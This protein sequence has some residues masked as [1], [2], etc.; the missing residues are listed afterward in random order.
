MKSVKSVLGCLLAATGFAVVLQATLITT[1]TDVPLD[2]EYPVD[3]PADTTNVWTG[4]FSG[5]GSLRKTGLGLLVLANP[6]NVFT[7]GIAID[8]GPLRADAEGALGTEKIT[9]TQGA[10][11]RGCL[12]FNAQDAV[13]PNDIDVI[14]TY[15]KDYRAC[16]TFKNVTLTGNVTSTGGL[17]VE[18]YPVNGTGG[19]SREVNFQSTTWNGTITAKG[20]LIIRTYGTNVFNAAVSATGAV[21]F[22]TV[23]SMMGH[24]FLNS[25]DNSF[26]SFSTYQPKIYCGAANVLSGAYWSISAKSSRQKGWHSLHMNGYDQTLNYLKN[27]ATAGISESCQIRSDK[28][29]VL[30]LTGGSSSTQT[31]GHI[32]CG[33]VSLVVDAT[34]STFVQCF[35]ELNGTV[36]TH[37]TDGT[38]TVKKGGVQITGLKTT[39]ENMPQIDVEASGSLAIDTEGQVTF[40][41]VTTL[42]V[43]GKLEFGASAG[44]PFTDQLASLALDDGAELTVNTE[45][46]VIFG[47]VT[48]AGKPLANDDYTYPDDRVPQLKAGGFTVMGGAVVEESSWTGAG[49]Q[50]A[51]ITDEANW[52]ET[53]LDFTHGV[54]SP[55]FASGGSSATVSS[56][57][58]FKNIALSAAT[59][60]DGF[61]FA[62]GGDAGLIALA[63]TELTLAIA[64]D[65]K[66]YDFEVPVEGRGVT[67]D[68]K[69]KLTITVPTN[70]LLRLNGGVSYP[71]GSVEFVGN[72]GLGSVELR[73]E[74]TIGGA[75]T[76]PDGLNPLIAGRISTPGHVDQGAASKGGAYTLTSSDSGS[77]SKD[78]DGLLLDNALIEKPVYIP[79]GSSTVSRYAL[80]GMANSTNEIVGNLM[81]GK[82]AG[83]TGIDLHKNSE[84]TLCG[85]L[86]IQQ[87]FHFFGETG[88]RLLINEKPVSCNVAYKYQTTKLWLGLTVVGGEVVFG[89]AGNEINY[90]NVGNASKYASKVTFMQDDLFAAT[91]TTLTAG[92]AISGQKFVVA[93]DSKVAPI[94]EFNGTKQRFGR[95]AAGFRATFHGTEGSLL[96]VNGEQVADDYVGE[97]VLMI[98]APF[99]GA[100]GLKMNGTGTLVLSNGV[101]TSVGGVEVASG[102]LRFAPGTKW[103]GASLALSGDGVLSIPSGTRLKF[104]SLAVDGE[105]APGGLYTYA[106]APEAIR[107]HLAATSGAIQIGKPG[108]VLLLR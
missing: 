36:T 108:L 26:S 87:P 27:D 81:F 71:D 23:A 100:L 21:S 78:D 25:A 19:G 9:I 75:L 35:G 49:T 33:K 3:V 82:Q 53:G 22:G 62:K 96:E 63:G 40:P 56:E 105:P 80:W 93:T 39:F 101:N 69:K 92:L 98:A 43:A 4:C 95:V 18:N 59:G 102:E 94:V 13:F 84:L 46:K 12:Q 8:A 31:T 11:P 79:A 15:N 64:E 58:V 60:E 74:S 6:N 99:T 86:N 51:E 28:P 2:G 90:L 97:D 7:G 37:T 17:A 107:K 106:T 54:L 104:K 88:A 91:P 76:F 52:D 77:T 10:M 5:E 68:L 61:T 20:E 66:T 47:S 32:L 24:V 48:V 72:G 14:G 55:T 34:E 16:S 70:T 42:N 103:D 50:G 73:G 89:A 57:V 1:E 85:G 67:D 38:M 65:L 29:C 45:D 30:T 41:A 44:K 83:A